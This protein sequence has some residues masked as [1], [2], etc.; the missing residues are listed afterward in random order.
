MYFGGTLTAGL[1]SAWPHWTSVV[2]G[3]DVIV[4]SKKMLNHYE[5]V[6]MRLCYMVDVVTVRKPLAT[7][8][9]HRFVFLSLFY[10]KFAVSFR[11]AD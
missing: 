10:V 3:S 6:M 4:N 2:D 9:A 7:C 8:H 5:S 11:V 1:D